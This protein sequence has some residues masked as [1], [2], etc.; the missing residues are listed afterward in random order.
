MMQALPEPL[1]P[2]GP[3]K[4][5][6]GNSPNANPPLPWTADGFNPMKNDEFGDGFNR[7]NPRKLIQYWTKAVRKRNE[8]HSTH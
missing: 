2:M 3:K 5:D 6:C 7:Q 1:S 8:G 4:N